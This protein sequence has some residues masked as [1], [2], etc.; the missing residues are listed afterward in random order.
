MEYGVISEV[1]HNQTI[2]FVVHVDYGVFFEVLKNLEICASVFSEVKSVFFSDF[3]FENT[4]AH[5]KISAG[6]GTQYPNF[7][8]CAIR[9]VLMSGHDRP[10]R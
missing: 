5:G 1:Y 2:V 9:N 8:G 4:L 3:I 6:T 10:R 7:P